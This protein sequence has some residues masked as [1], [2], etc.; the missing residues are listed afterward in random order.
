MHCIKCAITF[1]R[2]LDALVIE[3]YRPDTVD[4]NPNLYDTFNYNQRDYKADRST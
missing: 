2:Y 4:T 1:Y 3:H